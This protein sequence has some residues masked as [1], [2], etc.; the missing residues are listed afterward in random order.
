MR[1]MP[2]T[3]QRQLSRSKVLW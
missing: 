2:N 1:T 3:P